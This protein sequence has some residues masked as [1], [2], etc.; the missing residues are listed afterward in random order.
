MTLQSIFKFFIAVCASVVLT[1]FVMHGQSM[2]FAAGVF[3]IFLPVFFVRP[4]VYFLFFMFVRPVVDLSF[5]GLQAGNK[6]SS[7]MV[8]PLIGLCVKDLVMNQ[9]HWRRIREHPLLGK[10][11]ALMGLIL[12]TYFTSFVY[13]ENRMVSMMDF[14]R[15]ISIIVSVNYAV[16]V[17]PS[18]KEGK[19]RFIKVVLLSSLIP[20]AMGFWQMAT[21]SGVHERGY[22][23]ILGTFTHP[24]VYAE[25]L[26]LL[27][28]LSFHSFSHAP[29]HSMARR[30]SGLLFILSIVSF[31]FTYTRTLWIAFAAALVVFAGL[32]K[33]SLKKLVYL[34]LVLLVLGGSFMLVRSRFSDLNGSQSEGRSSLQWRIDLW[35]D[36]VKDLRIHP[37]LGNGLGM[38]E[39]QVGVMAHNDLIRV[40]YES[41]IPSAILFFSLFALLFF[42]SVGCLRGAPDSEQDYYRIAAA[43]VATLFIA[44]LAV[45]TLR[46][47][48]IM[49]YY[50]CAVIVFLQQPKRFNENPPRQ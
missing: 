48:V 28:F 8:V 12:C 49:F 13:T 17:F 36:T 6:V 22:N 35:R 11:N 19:K 1:W 38:F 5:R 46:S 21:H 43:L 24:N 26:A 45:N 4:D 14:L 23:R 47:T 29:R 20:L 3:L 39:Y 10:V 33:G 9:A 40:A 42:Y 18:E 2:F 41:G 27:I 34:G 15:F 31:V 16:V 7:L 25:F 32:K 44:G 50:F 30:L 37:V